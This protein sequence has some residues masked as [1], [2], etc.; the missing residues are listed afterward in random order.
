M[1]RKSVFSLNAPAIFQSPHN[2]PEK[3]SMMNQQ[4][5]FLTNHRTVNHS[6]ITH[7]ANAG[8]RSA[9]KTIGRLNAGASPIIWDTTAASTDTSG[10]PKPIESRVDSGRTASP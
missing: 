3:S 8:A 10:F 7:G 2:L 4:T 1:F 5:T 6:P 9:G